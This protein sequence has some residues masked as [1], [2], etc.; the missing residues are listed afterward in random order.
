MGCGIIFPREKDVWL[1]EDDE[2]TDESDTDSSTSRSRQNHSF[3]SQDAAAGRRNADQDGLSASSDGDDDHDLGFDLYDDRQ[4][5]VNAGA[6]I[7]R[8]AIARLQLRQR[9]SRQVAKLRQIVQA[10]GQ[11]TEVQVSFMHQRI[12]EECYIF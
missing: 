5:V 7:L 11:T 4:L 8:H 3:V 6:D 12:V 10:L 9:P 2:S 1:S